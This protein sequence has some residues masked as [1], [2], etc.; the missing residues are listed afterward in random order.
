MSTAIPTTPAI[1]LGNHVFD[2]LS[3]INRILAAPA[4]SAHPKAKDQAPTTDL[5]DQG[6]GVD[7]A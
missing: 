6:L 2:F 4:T 1:D 5:E 3:G 7:A